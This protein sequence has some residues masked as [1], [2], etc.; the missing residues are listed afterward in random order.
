MRIMIHPDS[1]PVWR[2]VSRLGIS[3]TS[4]MNSSIASS[5]GSP[6]VLEIRTGEAAMVSA[7]FLG[8]FQGSHVNWEI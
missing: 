6:S 8:R 1:V 2:F 7:K 5:L 4:S 3:S